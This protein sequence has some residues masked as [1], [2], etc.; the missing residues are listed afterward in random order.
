MKTKLDINFS[1]HPKEITSRVLQGRSKHKVQNLQMNTPW[2]C[3]PNVVGITK[4]SVL[5]SA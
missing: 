5:H 1:L 4:S 2:S 3:S